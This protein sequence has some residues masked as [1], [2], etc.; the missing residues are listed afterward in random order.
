[1]N[2][3]LWVLQV[4]L[5]LAFI[6]AGVMKG[7]RP[8]DQLAPSLPWTTQVPA[9]LVRFIGISELVGGVGLV[10]PAITGI[11]PWLTPLAAACLALVMLLAAGFHVQRQEYT[12][13]APS[14]VLMLLSIAVA[15]GRF[16]LAPFA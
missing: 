13:I 10:L 6:A 12:T 5:A 16:A 14:I 7:F 9:S 1:M 4:L 15:Y 8:L 11:A 3:A 2:I